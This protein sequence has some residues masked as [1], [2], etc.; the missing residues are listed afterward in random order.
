MTWACAVLPSWEENLDDRKKLTPLWIGNDVITNSMNLVNSIGI[1]V[2]MLLRI[3][4]LANNVGM[5]SASSYDILKCKHVTLAV[6]MLNNTLLL[7][8]KMPNDHLKCLNII[9]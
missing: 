2:E 4:Y 7:H 1:F 6:N 5:N 8:T 3:L 9:I